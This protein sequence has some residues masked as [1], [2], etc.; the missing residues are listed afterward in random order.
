MNFKYLSIAITLLTF[1]F[2]PKPAAKSAS[3]IIRFNKIVS[4]DTETKKIVIDFLKWYR[5]NEPMLKKIRMVNNFGDN[6]TAKSYTVNFSGTEQYLN[7]LDK[8]GYFTQHYIDVWRKYFKYAN[9]N[10]KNKPQYNGPPAGFETDY[11]MWI[12]DYRDM[13]DNV[14][15]FI[16]TKT[17]GN[18][19]SETLIV[20]YP[21]VEG[22]LTYIMVNEKGKWKI[23][24]IKS[25]T[26]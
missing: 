13:L 19:K 22:H 18:E 4:K 25:W 3:G 8:S 5:D 12:Q 16:V 11:I 9:I 15:K 7:E 24:A 6:D 2:I 23:D 14:K 17:E 20:E 1:H 21:N 26:K 10:F